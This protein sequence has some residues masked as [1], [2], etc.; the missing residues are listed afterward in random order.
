MPY[1]LGILSTHPIQYYSPWYRA[2]ASQPDVELM[3]Y[4]AYRQTAEGFGAGVNG[5]FYV[6]VKLPTPGDQQALTILT[7]ALNSDP[8]VALSSKNATRTLWQSQ[9]ARGQR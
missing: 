7:Q 5:P 3:V 8:G 1:R 6:A 2:L 9:S 4:Y